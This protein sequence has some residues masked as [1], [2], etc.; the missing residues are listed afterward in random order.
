MKIIKETLK[1]FTSTLF[2]LLFASSNATS[3][4]HILGEKVGDFTAKMTP[5]EVF[6]GGNKVN[7]HT[8][9]FGDYGEMFWTA[10]FHNDGSFTEE[11]MSFQE[12]GKVSTFS[13]TGTWSTVQKNGQDT[14]RWKVAV[15][16]TNSDGEKF[17]AEST[18]DLATMT[19]KGSV[20]TLAK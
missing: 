6:K 20:Y 18:Y 4:G 10:T 19:N 9:D 14:H 5:A 13:S 2:I 15:I 3:D 7:L 8:K 11:G 17:V 1:Y 16:V 12:G